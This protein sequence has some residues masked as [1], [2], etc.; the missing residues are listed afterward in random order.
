MKVEQIERYLCK[1][2]PPEER[3]LF[4][5]EMEN[6]PS[7]KFDVQLVA[8]VIRK[9]REVCL[10]RD[11]E[12]VARM[13][14]GKPQDKKR[15]VTIVAAMLAV[16]FTVVASLIF[17][18]YLRH[19]HHDSPPASAITYDKDENG[20][21]VY[22]DI[23]EANN[24]LGDKI[25]PIPIEHPQVNS[26]SNK[27]NAIDNI[28]GNTMI[29]AFDE[30][31]QAEQPMI[32]SQETSTVPDQSQESKAKGDRSMYFSNEDSLAKPLDTSPSNQNR[33][34]VYSKD[35]DLWCGVERAVL[36]NN[37]LFIDVVLC[38][39]GETIHV[40]KEMMRRICMV[41]H[42]KFYA[43]RDYYVS[44]YPEFSL[45]KGKEVKARL[46]FTD[47]DKKSLRDKGGYFWIDQLLFMGQ[48]QQ[49]AKS[50]RSLGILILSQIKID[51]KM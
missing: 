36:S 25:L 46:E 10:R 45:V 3:E 23:G 7:L 34:E 29:D 5:K 4:E 41:S 44:N 43:L 49:A 26:E 32:T 11:K 13:R 6:N 21:L 38:S 19:R 39:T 35:G 15:Y 2:M 14:E 40:D 22:S 47:I 24:V 18:G 50:S 20:F 9:T 31:S 8:C 28:K 1:D 27:Q 30:Q 12:L 16:I 42:Q 33:F 48:P 37:T 17:F 51:T